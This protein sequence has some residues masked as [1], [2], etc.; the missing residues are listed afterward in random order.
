MTSSGSADAIWIA[1]LAAAFVFGLAASWQR[2]GNPLID[3]GREMHQPVRLL[4]GETLYSDVRHIYGPISPWLHA[5]LYRVFGPSLSVLYAD[6]ILCATVML[7]LLYWLGRQI[8]SPAA[9]GAATLSV[10]WLCVFKPAGNYI[11]PYSYNALHGTV[12]ALVTLVIVVAA[13]KKSDRGGGAQG[14]GSTLSNDWTATTRFVMAGLIAGLAALAKTEMGLAAVAAGLTGAFLA[15]HPRRRR[16]VVLAAAF[17]VPA[18][19]L[20]VAT[21]TVIAADVGWNTLMSDS[22]L[23][24]YNAPPELALFN[25]RISGFDQPTRSVER[26]IIAALKLVILG[27]VIGSISTI[28]AARDPTRSTAP[29]NAADPRISARLTIPWRVLLGAFVLFGLMSVTTGLDWDKGPYLA[30]P[31]LLVVLLVTL[32][33]QHQAQPGRAIPSH[34]AILITCSVYALVSLARTILHVRSGGAY[35]AYLLPVSVMIFT[36]AWMH[37][38]ADRL[39]DPQARRLARTIVL[40]LLIGDAVVTAGLLAYRYRTRQTVPISTAR[41]TIVAARD[42][43]QAWNEALAYIAAHTPAGSAIA[44]LPEGTSINFLGNRRNPLREE[45]TTPGFLDLAGEA[46]AIRQLEQSRAAL[47][48]ITNR[49]TREFGPEAFGRDY[50]RLLM[51]WIEDHYAVCAMFGPVKDPRLEIGDSPFF[52]RAYCPRRPYVGAAFRRPAAS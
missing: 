32:V 10:M 31:V 6:G 9:A 19:V 4:A 15:T 47:I 20:P 46:R 30:M 38:F 49:P 8:M 45:I 25:S 21:Y 23:L 42:L 18:V 22:W 16:G 36:Y 41:G 17:T 35:G 1:I 52:I 24:L 12:L 2:W 44:V 27:A 5:A 37:P 7:A 33:R 29:P 39:R 11:L 26:M 43:G 51:R 40:V 28:V 3:T 14:P 50:D 34:D 13:L 48:L